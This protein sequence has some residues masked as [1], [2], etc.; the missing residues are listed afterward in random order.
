MIA[1]EMDLMALG[2]R[3]VLRTVRDFKLVGDYHQPQ[4]LY[5]ALAHAAPDVL[6]LSERFD[7]D[8][9]ALELLHH[10]QVKIP[11]TRILLL[12]T[13]SSGL[14]I[15]DLLE[16][17]AAGYLHRGDSLREGLN[18]AIWWVLRGRAI[19]SPTAQALVL[20]SAS[21]R[22]H[23]LDEEARSVLRLLAEGLPVHEIAEQL[24]LTP[25]RV[26]RVRDK[27][28]R[29]FDAVTNEHLIRRA[30]AEG[31]TLPSG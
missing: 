14:L 26:Y 6:L 23:T 5:E 25:R 11:Q 12:G 18:A 31:L 10:F 20:T 15:G 8:R 9:E 3:S 16:A 24:L 27:L 22:L 13:L 1:D 21:A 4:K 30:I 2:A 7:P 17:G 28:R 19:L 29:R